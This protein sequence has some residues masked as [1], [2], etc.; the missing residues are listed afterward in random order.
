MSVRVLSP[1]GIKPNPGLFNYGSIAP[2]FRQFWKGVV[3]AVPLWE[4]GGVNV[5]DYGPRHLTSTFFDAD[6]TWVKTRGT[7]AL[8]NANTGANEYA[9]MFAAGTYEKHRTAVSV[10]AIVN[11]YA[12]QSGKRI[13]GTTDGNSDNYSYL[14]ADSTTADTQFRWRLPGE[15]S[16]S[17]EVNTVAGT[18]IANN[19]YIVA[20]TYDGASIAIYQDGVLHA[21]AARTGTLRD[22]LDGL[23]FLGHDNAGSGNP[24]VGS[25]ELLIVWN[26]GLSHA[27]VQQISADPYGMFRSQPASSYK[28]AAAP[29]GISVPIAWHHLNKNIGR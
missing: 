19:R 11:T 13:C 22:Q 9:F 3:V 26:R 4:G 10:L 23:G 28:A 20:S 24:Y 1:K 6:V 14:L 8:N 21:S 17:N 16:G 5:Q 27:E 25:G 2:A 15:V 7:H 12:I 29:A 18:K